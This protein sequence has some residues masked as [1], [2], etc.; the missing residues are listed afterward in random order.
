M[1]IRFCPPPPP[2]AVYNLG[3]FARAASSSSPNASS[4][5]SCFR[6]STT[7]LSYCAGLV[8]EGWWGKRHE[9]IGDRRAVVMFVTFMA[10]AS[11]SSSAVV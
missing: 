3:F 9:A 5:S 7:R 2:Y 6:F 4:P 8:Y 1:A 10:A 11:S